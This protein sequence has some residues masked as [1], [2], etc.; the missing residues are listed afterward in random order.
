MEQLYAIATVWVITWRFVWPIII[1]LGL[2]GLLALGGAILPVL[3]QQL[4][5]PWLFPAM[6]VV[7]L[8]GLVWAGTFWAGEQSLPP[9]A[10]HW[11]SFLHNTLS[12]LGIVVALGLA[13]RFRHVRRSWLIFICS[14]VVMLFTVA[15][16][17]VGAMAISNSWL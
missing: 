2:F 11:R 14:A 13:I 10:T 4:P 15:A 6:F 17:F 3:R 9:S 1:I 7:P 12:V 16:W 8:T 5:S